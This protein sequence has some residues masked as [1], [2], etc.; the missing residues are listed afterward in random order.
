MREVI[1]KQYNKITTEELAEKAEEAMSTD[2]H[3]KMNVGAACSFT[4]HDSTNKVKVAY[5]GTNINIS[6]FQTKVHAE[7]L[8]LQQ[9]LMELG[10]TSKDK[11]VVLNKMVVVTDSDSE[12]I[13]CGHCLQITRS[14]CEF[15]DCR[16]EGV[17]YI[18]AQKE[19][20]E[21]VY[22]YN[23]VHDLLGKTYAES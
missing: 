6:G 10:Q 8:A 22:N 18:G 21:Y 11:D 2:T 17:E 14:V 20:G 13:T 9:A 1:T 5:S 7:Q 23:Y 3:R 15:L 4:I 12:N 16:P 19:E